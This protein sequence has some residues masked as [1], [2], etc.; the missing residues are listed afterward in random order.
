ME[1]VAVVPDLYLLRFP[2]GNAYLWIGNDSLTLIDCGLPGSGPDIAAA[3]RELGH[4]P[5]EVSQLLLTHFHLDHVGAA[6]EVM[7]WGH[8]QVLAHRAD[9]PFITGQRGGP[10][11]ELAD[12]ERPLFDQVNRQLPSTSANPVPVDTELDDGTAVDLGGTHASVVGVPGHTP[13]SIALHV[14][15]RGVLLAGDTIARA[16]DGRVMLGV[17][18]ADG[19]AAELSFRRLAALEVEVVGFGHGDPL[20]ADGTA[21]LQAA[22]SGLL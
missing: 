13:G 2:I 22:C 8:A 4:H 5:A 12:W 11:P 3:I 17:F 18:N 14:P 7:S 20:T 19:N 10:P 9:A 21:R 6:A 15:G 1:L 16:P